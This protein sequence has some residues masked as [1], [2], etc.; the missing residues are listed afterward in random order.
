MVKEEPF[1]MGSVRKREAPDPAKQQGAVELPDYGNEYRLPFETAEGL[2]YDERGA[3]THIVRVDMASEYGMSKSLARCLQNH[4]VCIGCGRRPF[5]IE[6]HEHCTRDSVHLEVTGYQ[7]LK[8]PGYTYRREI[9]TSY[10]S[11]CQVL[12]AE[13]K[14]L[15]IQGELSRDFKRANKFLRKLR[16]PKIPRQLLMR[17]K[18]ELL[19][20]HDGHCYYCFVRIEANEYSADFDHFDPISFGGTGDV[21]NLV[22]ACKQCNHDKGSA[23]GEVF[24]NAMFV[25]ADKAARRALRILQA[26]V[27]AWRENKLRESRIEP[28][29]GGP[30]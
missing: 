11:L 6:A 23:P 13:G 16:Q 10:I 7:I 30:G 25:R 22:V 1:K 29:A 26:R 27:D 28:A 4:S 3:S 2:L 19:A 18:H 12:Y 8:L 24:R 5:P 14:D 17:L 15:L 9:R 21:W 20:L